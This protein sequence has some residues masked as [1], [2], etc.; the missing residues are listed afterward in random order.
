VAWSIYVQDPDGHLIE[1]TTYEPPAAR[2]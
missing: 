2:E 1:I